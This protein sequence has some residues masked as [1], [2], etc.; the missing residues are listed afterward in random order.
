MSTVAE[1][2][3]P[4]ANTILPEVFDRLSDVHVELESSV[5]HSLPCV[6]VRGASRSEVERAFETDPTIDSFELLVQTDDRMLYD[7]ESETI[8]RLF[9]HL[10]AHGGSLLEVR[11]TNDWW[12]VRMRF[13]NREQLTATHDRLQTQE[14]DV[15]LTRVTDVTRSAGDETQLT[16]EQYEALEAALEH[17]YFEIP[18][19]ISMEELAQK[20]DISH[21]ALSERLRR[22]Y[23]TLVDAE[24]QPANEQ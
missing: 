22:A 13:R 14:I 11:G 15:D 20:L 23:E 24:L 18:R 9:D 7:L 6:W 2:R 10:L 12:N 19:G 8:R 16:P 1:F 4:A 17:G 5:S 3:L 21:Q